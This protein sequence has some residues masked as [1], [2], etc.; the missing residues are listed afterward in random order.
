MPNNIMRHGSYSVDERGHGGLRAPWRLLVLCTKRFFICVLWFNWSPARKK[1]ANGQ[2]IEMGAKRK[3]S[4]VNSVFFIWQTLPNDSV[5]VNT[6]SHECLAWPLWR[7][8]HTHS[9]THSH[10]NSSEVCVCSCL[11][12]VQVTVTHFQSAENKRNLSSFT[13]FRNNF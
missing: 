7:S 5:V 12:K 13:V 8:T 10:T 11:L 1:Q 4:V 2:P 9:H 6:L 3:A